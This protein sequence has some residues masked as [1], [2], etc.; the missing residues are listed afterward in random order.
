M[1]KDVLSFLEESESSKNDH[2]WKQES[3]I[4]EKYK[5]FKRCKIALNHCEKS[6][7]IWI[8]NRDEVRSDAEVLV[9]AFCIGCRL[10]RRSGKYITIGSLSCKLGMCFLYKKNFFFTF[11]D[12]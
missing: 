3:F 2:L 8:D 5:Q 11:I 12:E 7:L 1:N 6:L 9:G 4:N 10:G